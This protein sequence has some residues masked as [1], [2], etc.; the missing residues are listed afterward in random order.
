MRGGVP[1]GMAPTVTHSS[2]W[3]PAAW[4]MS[5]DDRAFP[6]KPRRHAPPSFDRA[7]IRA[8]RRQGD[9]HQL[10]LPIKI[11][12]RRWPCRAANA[13][14]ADRVAI[15]PCCKASLHRRPLASQ[16]TPTLGVPSSAR[17]SY[18]PRPF[19]VGTGRTGLRALHSSSMA[20]WPTPWAIDP[21]VHGGLRPGPAGSRPR[22]VARGHGECGAVNRGSSSSV[23]RSN[24]D[25]VPSSANGTVASLGLQP[26][27]FSSVG[28]Q[29]GLPIGWK[30]RPA[31]V[32][33][34]PSLRIAV[35]Y[36]HWRR[37]RRSL[38]DPPVAVVV[39]VTCPIVHRPHR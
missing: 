27:F 8:N 4:S 35:G 39:P 30:S 31:A 2:S 19:G 24:R 32:G 21:S 15:D 26:S 7:G 9:P 14:P 28:F 34:R 25:G 29:A 1:Y 3:R 33:S 11:D 13:P 38:A 16:R 10:A 20:P 17:R 37:R 6:G 5:R 23:A 22:L 18:P 12:V 36:P